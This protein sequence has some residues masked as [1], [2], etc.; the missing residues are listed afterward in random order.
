M[1]MAIKVIRSAQSNLCESRIKPVDAF[2]FWSNGISV[3]AF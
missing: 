3:S 2:L 1:K